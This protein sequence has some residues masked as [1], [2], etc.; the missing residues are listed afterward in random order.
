MKSKFD[1]RGIFAC[2]AALPVLASAAQPAP[3]DIKNVSFNGSLPYVVSGNAKRDA[4]INHAIFL[5]MAGQPAPARYT[6]PVKAPE[7]QDGPTPTSE[8]SYSITRLDARVLAFEFDYE[9][10]GAYCEHHSEQYNFD[11]ATG[12]PFSSSDIFTPQGRAVLFKRNNPKRLEEYRKAIAG[13]NKEGAANRKKQRI[14]TPWPQARNDNRQ[15][16]EESRITESIDMYQHCM[17]SMRTPDYANFYLQDVFPVKIEEESITFLF[18]RCSNHAMQALDEVGDQ[19]ITY[20]ITELAPHLTPYG[21]YLLMG[22]PRN[23]FPAEPYQQFLFGRVGQAAITFDLSRPNADGSVMGSYF[24]NKYR[25]L[26]R[27]SGKVLGNTVE[28]A[29][30]ESTD[31]PQPLIRA[32]IKG[33]KLEGQWIGKQT[34][35]FSVSP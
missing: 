20:K 29:E 10:C 32:T 19:A 12:R 13:L 30:T 16:D 4:R 28:L 25:K 7:E 35:D 33:D 3:I 6:D 15:D 22:G 5:G 18:G 26:I 2:L 1:M 34:L 11:A 8:I 9:G 17:D 21:K 27:L 24:Y 23:T 14:A 31:T